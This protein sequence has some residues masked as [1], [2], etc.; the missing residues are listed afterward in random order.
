MSKIKTQSTTAKATADKQNGW[1]EVKLGDVATFQR[2]FDLPTKN[3]T[4]GTYP[5]MVSNGQDGTH[6]EYKVEAPGV[7]TGRSGTLGQV[8]F[9]KKNFWPLNTTLWVKDFHGNIP[10]FIYYFLKTLSLEYYNAG[11]GVPTLNRNHIHPLLVKVPPLPEQKAIAEVL[12]SLDEKIDLLHRQ[13]KTLENMAQALF[14]KWFVEEAQED[15]ED[16][17]L[18]DFVQ[19]TSG[20]NHKKEEIVDKGGILLSMGSVVKNYGFS[21]AASRTINTNSIDDKYFCYP[22]DIFVTTR[23]VTQNAELLGSPGIIPSYFINSK[24]VL[25]SNLYKLD[26]ISDLINKNYL[27]ELLKSD[28]YRE[29]VKGSASGTSVLMFKKS[30]LIN[31]KFHLPPKTY[32]TKNISFIGELHQKLDKNYSQI[33][34]LENMRDTLL[35][36]LMSG[37]VRVKFNNET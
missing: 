25:G 5:L 29:Y 34:T 33:H 23:D 35:P 18:G 27:L 16:V 2:G 10:Q 12:S 19:T 20:Y 17:K 28:R 30:D 11:S 37:V 24:I 9:V 36:K 32:L 3:R 7:V 14:R 1:R 8:F 13:N 4:T 15:W 22:A 26:V 6:S 21:L 31:F